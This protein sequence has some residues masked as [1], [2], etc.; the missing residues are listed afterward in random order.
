MKRN[1]CITCMYWRFDDERCPD[2]GYT[3]E[4]DYC[5]SYKTTKLIKDAYEK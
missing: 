5:L 4:D 2:R 3:D 1:T